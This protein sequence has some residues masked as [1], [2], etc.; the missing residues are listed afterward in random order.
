MSKDIIN[1]IIKRIREAK[2]EEEG[3]QI[4]LDNI[5]L[6]NGTPEVALIMASLKEG[7]NDDFY[8]FDSENDEDIFELDKGLYKK[9][10]L[11]K[12]DYIN[13]IIKYTEKRS[14]FY[15][16]DF[17]ITKVDDYDKAQME[18]LN[19]FVGLISDYAN[20]NDIESIQNEFGVSYRIKYKDTGLEIGVMH[21]NGSCCYAQRIP[22]EEGYIDFSKVM[23]QIG[24]KLHA[25][26]FIAKLNND[27]FEKDIDPNPGEPFIPTKENID[28]EVEE[29]KKVLDSDLFKGVVGDKP[30]TL[31]LEPKK[32]D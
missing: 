5:R 14:Q 18:I 32:E 26:S 19:I 21:G 10:M 3:K 24:A 7:P 31:T 13:W 15:D 17:N 12:P 30:K 8:E 6:I 4:L 16:D 27:E 2:T 22:V 20:D 25:N 11:T 28:R 23:V 1:D 29:F 9:D